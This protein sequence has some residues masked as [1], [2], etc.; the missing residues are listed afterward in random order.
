MRFFQN[1]KYFSCGAPICDEYRNFWYLPTLKWIYSG[2]NRIIE[3]ASHP[4]D[5]HNFCR[6]GA[7]VVAEEDIAGPSE[8]HRPAF[9][10]AGMSKPCKLQCKHTNSPLIV[11]SK[12]S[13][14]NKAALSKCYVAVGST[15]EVV[16]SKHQVPLPVRG[17]LVKSSVE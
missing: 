11:V 4:I 17:L 6:H 12:H 10:G 15:E 8:K 3:K 9:K 2:A 7:E 1:S 5:I 13:L 14:Y 16:G